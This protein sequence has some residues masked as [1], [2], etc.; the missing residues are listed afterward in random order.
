MIKI[1]SKK[2]WESFQDDLVKAECLRDEAMVLLGDY[3]I[4]AKMLKCKGITLKD[5]ETGKAHISWN[6]KGAP[7]KEDSHET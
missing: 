5:L 6:P 7:K 4:I 3:E 1:M 2:K